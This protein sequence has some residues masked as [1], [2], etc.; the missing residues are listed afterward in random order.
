MYVASLVPIGRGNDADFK[1]Y[2]LYGASASAPLLYY[3]DNVRDGRSYCTRSV[4]AVQ[5]GRNVFVMLCSFQVPEFWQPSRQ[6]AM[7]QAPHPD[8][9]KSEVEYL[10][11]MS[12][13][14]G[15]TEEARSKYLAYAKVRYSIASSKAMDR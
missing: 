8:K 5:A 11:Q 2:F 3:V 9:C 7:P 4:R 13:K 6:W 10:N 15:I 1:A 14:P 12:A